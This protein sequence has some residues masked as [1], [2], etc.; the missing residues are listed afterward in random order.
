[1]ARA[2]LPPRTVRPHPLTPNL[3]AGTDARTQ[4]N[5]RN[6]RVLLLHNRYRQPGGEDVVVAAQAQLLR[7]RGHDVRVLEKDNRAIDRYGLLKKALLFYE[8]SGNPKSAAE[9]AK[10]AD[11]FKPDVALIHNFLPLLSPSIY[12][13]LKRRGVKIVQYLHNYRLVCPAGTL[14]R[15]GKACTLC[16]DEGLSHAVKYRCWNNSKLASLGLTRMLDRHRRARTWHKQPDLFVA[17]N[18]YQRDVL[19]KAGVIPE[20]RT[21]VQPNFMADPAGQPVDSQAGSLRDGTGFV[22]AGRLTPEKGAATLLKAHALLDKVPLVVFGDGPQRKQL[23]NGAAVEFPGYRPKA[24][25]DA[26][27][28]SARAVIAPSEWQEVFGLSI[29]EAMGLSRAV[30][31]SRVAGPREIVEDGVTGLL[32]DAGN[33][34]QLAACMRRLQDDPQL[35]VKLGQ[36]GRARFEK[37]YSEEAG[38]CNLQE[39]FR[40]V[41]QVASA[42]DA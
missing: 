37:L 40:R 34:E 15:D 10:I 2:A 28:R 8:M 36:A 7:E 14:Y 16:I 42:P 29:I 35:A 1:M 27:I 23:M 24:E 12:A 39:V 11:E 31:A 3:V 30:I 32:F 17:L 26:R 20:E 21:I 18:S 38:Y 5:S 9:V 33:A 13:P 22:Y 6:P 19:I 4:V 41:T 25:V